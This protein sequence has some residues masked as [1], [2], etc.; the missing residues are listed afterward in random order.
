MLPPYLGLIASDDGGRS[1]TSV[2]RVGEVPGEPSRFKALGAERL[3]LALS[4]GTIVSTDDGGKTWRTA[5][6]P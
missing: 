2:S 5:F 6:R 1:W 3:D 4:D